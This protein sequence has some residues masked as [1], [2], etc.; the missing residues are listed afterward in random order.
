MFNNFTY[1]PIR[2]N[3]EPSYSLKDYA[4]EKGISTRSLV[5]YV[6]HDSSV[7]SSFTRGTTPYYHKSVLDA[8]WSVNH[9]KVTGNKE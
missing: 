7:T 3:K 8:W 1:E 9:E 2:D 6:R 5:Q 4:E